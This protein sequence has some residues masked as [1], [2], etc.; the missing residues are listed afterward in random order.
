M[1]KLKPY[2]QLLRKAWTDMLVGVVEQTQIPV[3][4]YRGNR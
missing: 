3:L 1:I 4:A 2:Q